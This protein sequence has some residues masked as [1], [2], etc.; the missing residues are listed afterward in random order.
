MIHSYFFA[1]RHIASCYNTFPPIS[2][3]LAT[4]GALSGAA[5]C[6]KIFKDVEA[7]TPS[8]RLHKGFVYACFTVTGGTIGATAQIAAPV[9]SAA[10]IA[11]RVLRKFY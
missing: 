6:H 7:K 8:D 9:L 3:S 4:L 11:Y 5:F 10:F 1:S 2:K